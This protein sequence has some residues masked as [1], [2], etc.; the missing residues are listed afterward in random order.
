MSKKINIGK[1]LLLLLIP[2]V[3]I[4]LYYFATKNS[5]NEMC[6]DV[7]I[8]INHKTEESLLIEKDIYKILGYPAGKSQVIGKKAGDLKMNDMENILTKNMTIQKAE[9]YIGISGDLKIEITERNPILRVIPDARTG[10]YICDDGTKIPLSNNYT[11]DLIPATGFMNDKIDRK[12]YYIV[13]FVNNNS[14]WK[15]QI[16]QFFVSENQ[17]VSFV[18]FTGVHEVILG[19]TSNLDEKFKKLEVFYKKGLSKLGWNKYKLINLK[20]KGQVICK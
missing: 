3:L 19:D 4:A 2:A 12:L 5:D 20:F 13:G 7:S 9:V 11:P 1:L 8:T 15:E 6:K 18:P 10:Y 17:D 16:Q 14:F